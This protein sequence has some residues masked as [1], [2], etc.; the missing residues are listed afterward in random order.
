MHARIV[1]N[2]AN[3]TYEMPEVSYHAQLLGAG[4]LLHVEKANTNG[5][6]P[7]AG[8]NDPMAQAADAYCGR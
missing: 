1:L 2:C 3:K 5:P 4:K 8:K 6:Q 7:F